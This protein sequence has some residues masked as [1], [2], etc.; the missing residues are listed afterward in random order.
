MNQYDGEIP[1]IRAMGEGVVYS[2]RA[3]I[4]KV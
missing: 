4:E 1:N 3:I 2:F